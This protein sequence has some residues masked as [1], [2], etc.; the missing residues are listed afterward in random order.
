[1]TELFYSLRLVLPA[2]IG[3]EDEWDAFALEQRQGFVG[4]R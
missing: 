4:S 1:L 2:A 3:E